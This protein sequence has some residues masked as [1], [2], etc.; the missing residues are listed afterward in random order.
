MRVNG[1]YAAAVADKYA[2]TEGVE[3]NLSGFR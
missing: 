3:R 2:A 1:H